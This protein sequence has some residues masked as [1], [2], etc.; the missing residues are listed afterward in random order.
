MIIQDEEIKGIIINEQKYLINQYNTL[1]GL[2]REHFNV[3]AEEG[4]LK[5][6]IDLVKCLDVTICN[7]QENFIIIKNI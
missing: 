5:R 2:I 6:N 4:H 3:L 7:N 1:I